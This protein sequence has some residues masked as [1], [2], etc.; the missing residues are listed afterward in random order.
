MKRLSN[1]SPF[2]LLLLPVFIMMLFT[3]GT[4]DSSKDS[5][6]QVVLKTNNSSSLVKVSNNLTK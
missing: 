2:I 4:T 6:G 5:N 1:I 3:F